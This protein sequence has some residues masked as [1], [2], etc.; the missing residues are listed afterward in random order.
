VATTT[1]FLSF[2]PVSGGNLTV[3]TVQNV[4]ANTLPAPPANF[5]PQIVAASMAASGDGNFIY[6]L[7]DTIRF[8]YDVRQKW[9]TSLGYTST[10]TM[11]RA[12]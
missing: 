11:G 2:D 1:E 4:T 6:G 8:K 10:P 7:T 9:V 5:P 3:G 12:W